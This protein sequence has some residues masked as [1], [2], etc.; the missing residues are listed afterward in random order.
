MSGGKFFIYS[1]YGEIL[2]LA[3]HLQQTGNEVVF[4]TVDHVYESIGE[5]L[6]H[7]V[8]EWFPFLEQDYT[9]IFDGCSDGKLQDWLRSKGE[10]VFG[11]SQRGDRMENDRQLNQAWFKAAGFHQPKSKN[12]T[13]FDSALKFINEHTDALWI[14]KQNGEAPK[15]LSH[16]GKFP[17]GVDMIFHLE[18]LKKKWNECEFGP[19]DFDLAEIVEGMEV[20]ASA[21][22]NGE[23]FLRAED[24]LLTGFLNFEEKKEANGGTGETCG[25]MGT[26][27]IQA[28]EKNKLFN[29]ILNRPKII[30]GLQ[31][32][33]F[34]GVFD[35][36]CIVGDKGITALEPTMRCGIPATSYE[37]EA[38][39]ANCA[40]VIN[41]CA[42]GEQV[43]PQ[44]TPGIGMVMCVVA[45]PF[46]IEAEVAP[47]ASSQG[48]RL[49][50]LQGGVPQASLS[51][52]QEKHIHL[53]NF[54]YS[55]NVYRVATKNG[56]LL[57]V[58]A[59]G[60]KISRVRSGL[61]KY[62]K[63]N[64]YLSGMKYRTD[65]G[66]RVEQAFAKRTKGTN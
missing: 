32:M 54:H 43:V 56:Y 7:K 63:D 13:D 47:E 59:S 30:E 24:G 8:K 61:I 45:K 26:T 4:H 23:D 46:P 1:R 51:P 65:I 18:E 33:N 66:V 53:Y 40:D 58:T 29:K 60:D 48:E 34:R 2:D 57:T 19:I 52:D 55:D 25:E 44:L 9:W 12:F 10:S 17:G 14:L 21:F 11:G 20:A 64:L 6:V 36:N 5:G 27:F 50:V 42:K 31:K 62:I 28:T 3:L 39:C 49:W 38:G 15:G 22:F 37:M 16:M 41:A 35:I